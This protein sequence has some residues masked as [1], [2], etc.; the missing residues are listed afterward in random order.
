MH[1]TNV[2]TSYSLP[3]Q[4]ITQA[5]TTTKTQQQEQYEEDMADNGT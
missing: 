1:Q 4:V 2:T 5:T 3:P